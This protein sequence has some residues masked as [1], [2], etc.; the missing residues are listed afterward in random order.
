VRI[1]RGR[2]GLAAVTVALIGATLSN[3]APAGAKATPIVP[4][5]IAA[6]AQPLGKCDDAPGARCGAVTVPLDRAHPDNRTLD[7][8]F[9]LYEH[10]DTSQPALDPIVAVEG[11]PGYSSRGSRGY[12]L[13][14]FEPLMNRR[15]LLI[16][17]NRGTGASGAI[18]CEQLQSYVGSLAANVAA[19]GKQLGDAADDYATGNAVEDMVAVLDSLGIEKINLYGDSYG[20]FF[21]QTFTVRHPDRIRSVVM[22]GAY[23]I[24]AGDPWNR[25]SARTMRD[26]Y[27][28]VC[29]RA[30]AC[31]TRGGDPI[32]R[33]RAL[34]QQLRKHPITGRAA[35]ADGTIQNVTIDAPALSYLAWAGSGSATV[36][37]ELDAAIRAA[38]RSTHP[39]FVPILRLGAEQLGVGDA[40]DPVDFSEGLYAA[41]AC[42]DYPQLWD[43]SQPPGVRTSQLRGSIVR[44]HH[45]DPDAFAPF[46]VDEWIAQ[47]FSELDSCLR[48]PTSGGADPPRPPGAPYPRVPALVLTSD[49]D[50]NTS[51]AGAAKVARQFGGTLVESVNSTHVSALG[52]FGRCAS[53]IVIRFIRS[54]NPGDTSCS[55]RYSENRLVD[56]FPRTVAGVTGA[57]P[58]EK[59]A[60]AA[61]ATAADV[62]ARWWSMYG[63]GGVGLRGGTFTAKG[64]ISVRFRLRAVKWVDDLEVKGTITWQRDTGAI[65]A[66][67]AT[68]RSDGSRSRLTM[69]WNDWAPLAR[70]TISGTVDRRPVSLDVP[71]P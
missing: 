48:W 34:T 71:A 24:E 43:P 56:L 9:E 27:R 8:A 62:V 26:A 70:A 51:P 21:G 65:G 69:S 61:A 33:M 52:D 40:G 11:G 5:K 58:D 25:D 44:L 53:D 38:L 15:D 16:V 55:R 39:D 10:T 47:P 35:D 1:V 32:N 30:P 66:Q 49:L 3:A 28:L 64:D 45:D 68:R 50:S 36:Y 18:N 63:E 2:L 6:Q 13:D 14:L 46:T 17:D 12:Y 31:A 42:R 29:A 20:T 7:I 54:L 41:V 23:P 59:V 22:D 67:L 4:S 57:T 60:R 37:R 19:C